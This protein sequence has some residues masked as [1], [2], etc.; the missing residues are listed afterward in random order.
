MTN[1]P[2]LIPELDQAYEAAAATKKDRRIS[3]GKLVRNVWVD[4]AFEQP[5]VKDSWLLTWSEIDDDQREVDMR[6]GE[7]VEEA[8]LGRIRQFIDRNKLEWM[9]RVFELLD[10]LLVANGIPTSSEV[11]DDLRRLADLVEGDNTSAQS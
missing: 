4:W 7:A 2:G 9:I 10:A 8:T 1:Q 5:H 11:Q 6:I 3:L